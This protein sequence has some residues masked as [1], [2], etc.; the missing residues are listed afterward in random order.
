[1]F[2]DISNRRLGLPGRQL[3]GNSAQCV[4]FDLLRGEV[5]SHVYRFPKRNLL[6][7]YLAR[8]T[9]VAWLVL[10]VLL[11]VAAGL[12]AG[13][14]QLQPETLAAWNTYVHASENRAADRHK[15]SHFLWMDED[16]DRARRVRAGE[17][18]VVPMDPH[19]PKSVP[20]G[21]I[22]DWIGA[23]FIPNAKLD[24]LF[25]VI[26]DY[27]RY[28]EFYRPTA[29]DSKELSHDANSEGERYAFQLR[30]VN[31]AVLLK[32]G[33]DTRSE[34]IYSRIDDRHWACTV[35]AIKIREIQNPGDS[36]E[37]LLP[38]DEGTGYIWRLASFSRF[39]ERDG[40]V[41]V[42]LEALALTRDVPMAL[43]FLVNP[44]I[45][46]IARGSL[47]TSL[48]QSSLAVETRMERAGKAPAAGGHGQSMIAAFR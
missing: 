44:M 46:G 28:K 47:V 42:E 33:L 24:D 39:E 43:R 45:R 38:P 15:G 22:H 3:P 35:R 32:T 1:M 48:R 7:A 4:G 40:G 27:D 26:R 18:V 25:A 10:V 11:G 6:Y 14:M 37:R 29:V 41:Y 34:A 20:H 17:I 12:Q 36:D 31:R 9:K 19:M 30:L 13:E 23:A 16:A 8:R 21:L 2:F 5:L